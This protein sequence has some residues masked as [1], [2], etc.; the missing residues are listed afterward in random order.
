MQ[1]VCAPARWTAAGDTDL[2]DGGELTKTRPGKR[3][4]K[5]ANPGLLVPAKALPGAPG[6][7]ALGRIKRL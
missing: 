3:F 7:L 2:N 5:G 6:A 1:E 4:K